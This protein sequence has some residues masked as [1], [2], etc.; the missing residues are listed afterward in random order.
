MQAKLFQRG[1]EVVPGGQREAV[2]RP[3]SL[4]PEVDLV[5]VALK[6]HVLVVVEVQQDRHQDLVQ[7]AN[8]SALRGEV[9]VLDQLLGDG[10]A[11]GDDPAGHKVAVGGAGNSGKGKTPVL[12]EALVLHRQ[13]TAP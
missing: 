9:I 2:Y 12:V 8:Q 7:L 11:A 4:L 3:R 10:A 13:Q 5:D 1:I 6:N